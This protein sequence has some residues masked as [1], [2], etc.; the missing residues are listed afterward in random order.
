MAAWRRPSGNKQSFVSK[1]SNLCLVLFIH[2]AGRG[3]MYRPKVLPVL[4]A[5]R[6]AQKPE[7]KDTGGVRLPPRSQSGPQGS[8]SAATFARQPGRRQP[9]QDSLTLPH[10]SSAAHRAGQVRRLI[11]PFTQTH[12]LSSDNG[13][14]YRRLVPAAGCLECLLCGSTMRLCRGR[15]YICPLSQLN[16]SRTDW[17]RSCRGSR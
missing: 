12:H 13:S 14:L 17:R 2:Q 7:T 9:R 10:L 3:W 4:L 11:S 16:M 6:S 8:P 5:G 1:V 15:R